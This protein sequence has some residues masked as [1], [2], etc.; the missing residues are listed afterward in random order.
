MANVKFSRK[1][2]EKEI[3]KVDTDMQHK[4]AMFGTPVE[5]VTDNEIEL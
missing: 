3:G 4:I 2:F 5:S 1:V